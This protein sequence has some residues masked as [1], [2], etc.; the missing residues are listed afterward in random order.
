MFNKFFSKPIELHIGEQTFK[1]CSLS[2][3]EFSLAGRTSVPSKKITSMVKLSPEELKKEA[4]TIKGIEKRFV[5]ILSKSIEEPGSINRA[6]REMDPQIFSQDYGWRDII[7]ALNEG[8]VELDEFRRI[9]LVKYMQYLSSRQEIIKYLYSEK[10]KHTKTRAESDEGTGVDFKETLILENTLFEPLQRGSDNGDLERLP[11]GESVS[12]S[13]KSGRE[14]EI[15][16]SKHKCKLIGGDKIQFVDQSGRNY[17]LKQGRNVIGR[18]SISTVMLD[19]ALRDIS[20]LH[21]V[22]EIDGENR[23]QL[24][25]L[26]SHGTFMAARY[27]ANQTL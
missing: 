2:D 22:I 27:L 14:I 1:F 23:M 9:S 25:D 10:K 12:L 13:L 3:F 24:T 6:L 8:G 19:P 20:R 4:L 5:T 21:L 15:L 26:S 17:T 18:D 7:S 16:L 11:K